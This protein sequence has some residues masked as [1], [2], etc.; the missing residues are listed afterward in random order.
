MDNEKLKIQTIEDKILHN[1]IE[2]EANPITKTLTWNYILKLEKE[3]IKVDAQT[4]KKRGIYIKSAYKVILM[5]RRDM[6]R[7]Y[8]EVTDNFMWRNFSKYS[9]KPGK[10][11]QPV[12]FMTLTIII[13]M[14]IVLYP[15]LLN[16]TKDF[17]EIF[18]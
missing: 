13:L 2:G 18:L 3:R 8:S 16:T 9:F 15:S 12:I 17:T 14:F 4:V 1:P 5:L 6:F 11:Y 10:N 7:I